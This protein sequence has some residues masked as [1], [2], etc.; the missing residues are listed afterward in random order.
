MENL[1]EPELREYIRNTQ[2]NKITKLDLNYTKRFF[3]TLIHA[4]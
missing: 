3:K 4:K 2:M 1:Y